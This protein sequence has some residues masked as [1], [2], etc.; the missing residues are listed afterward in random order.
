[1]ELIQEAFKSS[2]VAKERPGLSLL[3]ERLGACH[4]GG[5]C[6]KKRVRGWLAI[7]ASTFSICLA[8]SLLVLRLHKIV[9]YNIEDIVNHVSS[10]NDSVRLNVN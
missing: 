1:M 3:T 4:E 5:G 8:V 7:A 10:N 9:Q 2:T 6:S